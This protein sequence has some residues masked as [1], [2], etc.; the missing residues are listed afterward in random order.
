MKVKAIDCR[1]E[2]E[3]VRSEAYKVLEDDYTIQGYD[4]IQEIEE[5]IETGPKMRKF[6]KA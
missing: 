1:K 2:I 5:M 4:P 6:S 3:G